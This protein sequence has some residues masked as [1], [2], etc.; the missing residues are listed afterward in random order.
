MNIIKR[1][2][3]RNFIRAIDKNINVQ[4]QKYDMECDIYEET[5]YIG[6]TYNPITDV[7][8]MEY[9]KEL[10]PECNTPVFLLSILHEIGH[11][12][13]FDA[14]LEDEKDILYATLKMGLAENKEQEEEYV[15]M[16]F[17]IPFE[18]EATLWGI[19]YAKRHPELIKKY[20][21]L[22]K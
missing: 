7:L 11:I 1:I 10:D 20:L 19:D 15:K 21:W 4:F 14:D 9:V 2:G 8:F 3:V 16:Y 22:C 5:V 13:T 6:K 12:M 17:R 18:T